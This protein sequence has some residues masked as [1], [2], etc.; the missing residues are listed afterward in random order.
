[1]L[2]K[3]AYPDLSFSNWVPSHVS[4]PVW[5][6]VSNRILNRVSSRVSVELVTSPLLSALRSTFL[7]PAVQTPEGI[8]FALHANNY[9]ENASGTSRL[10]TSIDV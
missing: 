4:N 9:K 8:T 7:F 1:M 10:E 6:P 5:N 2:L 3:L